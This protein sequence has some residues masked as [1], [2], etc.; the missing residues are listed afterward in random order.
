[1]ITRLAGALG[2]ESFKLYP[3]C[4]YWRIYMKTLDFSWGTPIY[5]PTL[6]YPKVARRC[7]F[8]LFPRI[9]MSTRVLGEDPDRAPML[10]MNVRKLLMFSICM[11][12]SLP[13]VAGAGAGPTCGHHGTKSWPSARSG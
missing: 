8:F 4:Q 10:A 12:A 13:A 5:K 7:T 1:M 3:E 11:K 2:P 6:E 9:P